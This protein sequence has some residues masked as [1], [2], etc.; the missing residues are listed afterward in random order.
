[1]ARWLGFF[2]WVG[3]GM[4]LGAV[5]ATAFDAPAD[6]LGI[7]MIFGVAGGMMAEALFGQ[8]STAVEDADGV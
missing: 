1:M 7:W 3:L 4:A 2:G 5:A 6:Q 8:P